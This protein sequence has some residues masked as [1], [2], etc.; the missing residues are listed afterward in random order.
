MGLKDKN[1]AERSY[2]NKCLSSNCT[3]VNIVWSEV[4]DCNAGGI[5]YIELELVSTSHLCDIQD[6]TQYDAILIFSKWR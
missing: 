5:I 2:T 6:V 4:V 3:C 1:R